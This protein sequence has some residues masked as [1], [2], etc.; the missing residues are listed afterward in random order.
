MHSA[1][2]PQAPPPMTSS[3]QPSV[4]EE[5]GLINIDF[6][7]A[8]G[9]FII[10][11]IAL[12]LGLLFAC[13]FQSTGCSLRYWRKKR[14]EVRLTNEIAEL[15]R[16]LDESTKKDMEAKMEAKLEEGETAWRPREAIIPRPKSPS[17]PTLGA[18]R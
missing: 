7:G 6:S 15:T 8:S 14:S 1:M 13:C 17:A 5:T 18:P 12:T 16:R 10:S 9:M 11:L 3:F 2:T 4:K